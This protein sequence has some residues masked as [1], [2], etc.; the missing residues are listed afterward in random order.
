MSD[1]E[2]RGDSIIQKTEVD[3]IIIDLKRKRVDEPILGLTSGIQNGD[4]VVDQT[5]YGSKNE[6]MAGLGG[7]A[8]QGL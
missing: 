6:K 4:N 5:Q 7:K 8:C 1:T 3:N 2:V